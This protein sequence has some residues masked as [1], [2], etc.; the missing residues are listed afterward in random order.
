M[1]ANDLFDKIKKVADHLEI[2]RSAR[3]S[4]IE[5]LDRANTI[6]NRLSKAASCLLQLE[7]EITVELGELKDEAIYNQ[8]ADSAS[9]NEL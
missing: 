8:V 1:Q 9:W 3:I 6:I 2:V 7:Q 5:R 4:T